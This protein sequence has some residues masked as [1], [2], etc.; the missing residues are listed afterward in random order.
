VM[1]GLARVV[2]QDEHVS[3]G[4][5]PQNGVVD[6]F[7]KAEDLA[8][9]RFERVVGTLELGAGSRIGGRR[10]ATAE[11]ETHKHD[12]STGSPN[13]NPGGWNDFHEKAPGN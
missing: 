13:G 9:E 1:N 2:R 10:R 4:G 7:V 8:V 6:N 11:G 12:D 5:G 3:L